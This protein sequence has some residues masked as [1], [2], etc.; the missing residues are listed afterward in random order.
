VLVGRRL[1]ARF[2]KGVDGCFQAMVEVR[3]CKEIS[4]QTEQAEKAASKQEQTDG[5]G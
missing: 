5:L 2:D 4:A 1:Q 3:S